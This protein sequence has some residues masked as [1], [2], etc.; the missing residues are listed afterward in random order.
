MKADIRM[1]EPIVIQAHDHYV[2]GT[3]F[4][5]QSPILI[6]SIAKA[7][8]QISFSPDNQWLAIGAA[9]RKVRIWPLDII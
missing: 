4:A 9:D 7:F 3:Y 2:I 8:Y 5:R 6:T 1:N